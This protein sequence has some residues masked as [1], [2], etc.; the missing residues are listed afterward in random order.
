MEIIHIREEQLKS[1]TLFLIEKKIIFHPTIS[2]SGCPDFT[3]RYERENILILDRNILTKLIEFCKTGE[4]RDPYI[5]KLIAALIFWAEANQIIITGGLAL[6]EYATAIGSNE[7]ASIENNIFLRMFEQYSPQL[8][9]DVFE[10]KISNI[11]PINLTNKQDFIFSVENDHYLMHLSEVIYLFRLYMENSLS[12]YEKV[13]RFLSWVDSH[14]LFCAYS[15][16]YACMLFSKKVKQPRLSSDDNFEYKIKRCQ[17]QAWDLTYLSLWSTLYWN[18]EN[19]NK[20]FLFATMDSDLK[21]IFENTH[22]TSSNL[23][24]RFFGA[25][26]GKLIQE[27]YD[28]LMCKR[29]KPIMTD[30]R[31]HEVLAFEQ[32]ALF[33][34]V[35]V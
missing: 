34:C 4:L 26:K 11:P 30:N 14:Q 25:Q 35:E 6:N 10:G 20:N 32:Q 27:H 12:S 28:R 8:W 17:N 19:T 29:V 33:N 21:K 7:C 23:F 1:L 5:R 3:G 16:T 13:I 2:P 31:I 9:L 22:D 18:E 15:I 24:S